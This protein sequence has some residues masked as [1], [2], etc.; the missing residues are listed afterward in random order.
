MMQ[1]GCSDAGVRLVQ[2]WEIGEPPVTPHPPTPQEL[3]T[4]SAPRVVK[5]APLILSPVHGLTESWELILVPNSSY[6]WGGAQKVLLL[7]VLACLL[8]EQQTWGGHQW[9]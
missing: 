2:V 1:P 3:L 8:E 5:E 6:I 7:G 4:N 9:I